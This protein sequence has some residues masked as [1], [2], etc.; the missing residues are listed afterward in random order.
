[1][2]K[3]E[4]LTT[5][6]LY[7]GCLFLIAFFF[8]I[9]SPLGLEA[10]FGV[11]PPYVKNSELTRNSVYEQKIM[12]V[13][14]SPD[15]DVLA[16]IEV[17]VPGANEWITIE[18]AQEILMPKGE[19]KIPLVVKILVPNKADFGE[20]K[21]NIRVKTSVVNAEDR[22]SGAVS[23]ALGARINV[24]FNVIDRIIKEFDIRK[25]K[26][27]DFNEGRR[28]R[29]LEYPGKMIFNMTLRNTGNVSVSPSKVTVDI[30]D[31]NGKKL[32]ERTEHSN[33]IRKVDPFKTEDV[34]AELPS[35][36]SPG[37][38]RA[39][40]VIYNDD[41]EVKTGELTFNIMPTGTIEGDFGYGFM[42]LSLWHKTTIVGPIILVFVLILSLLLYFSKRFRF[43][44]FRALYSW[45]SIYRYPVLKIKKLIKLILRGFSKRRLSKD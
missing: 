44:F 42:G 14:G 43:V 2:N 24:E 1:M 9:L 31:S 39:K 16:E 35:H 34:F 13:R 32:L 18:P 12:L 4:L 17:D 30:Y 29:W 23:I 11:T 41:E 38:Y 5:S 19:N 20:Y 28:I 26:I 10:G 33:R 7:K 3:I 37:S 15:Y 6:K 21:G 36:L 22:G 45:K 27:L 8:I 25:V 40:Y